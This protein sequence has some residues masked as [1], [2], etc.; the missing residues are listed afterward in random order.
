MYEKDLQGR[1]L[2]NVIGEIHTYNHHNKS[3]NK[4]LLFV[5]VKQIEKLSTDNDDCISINEVT[6]NGTVCKKTN[7]RRKPKGKLITDLLIASN[8][9]YG[10]TDYIPCICWNEIAKKANML[11]IGDDVLLKGRFQSRSYE[12][13]LGDIVLFLT[14]Y[15]VSVEK[16]DVIKGKDK[17]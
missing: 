9:L 17:S 6:I 10:K 15:E 16:L 4:L 3:E 13:Y 12:K 8:R 11:K 14:A 5:Y 1:D 2:V 7:I